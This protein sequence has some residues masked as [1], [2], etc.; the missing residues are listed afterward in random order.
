MIHPVDL[1]IAWWP[2]LFVAVGTDRMVDYRCWLS[3][4]APRY[5]VM[6]IS[7]LGWARCIDAA[8]HSTLI[9]LENRE[10]RLT[11]HVMKRKI[12]GQLEALS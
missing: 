2:C 8:N 6:G 7:A 9:G 1:P 12:I 3:T 10:K 11:L 5:P 4:D